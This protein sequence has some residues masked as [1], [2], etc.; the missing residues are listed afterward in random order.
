VSKN[1]TFK[2]LQTT[3]ERRNKVEVRI[4]KA[5]EHWPR[6]RAMSC[7]MS[8]MSI[9]DLEEAAKTICKDLDD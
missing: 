4:I 1:D 8:W 6:E 2:D 5:L 9:D 3:M 7:I